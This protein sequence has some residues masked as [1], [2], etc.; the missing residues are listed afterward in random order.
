MA[1]TVE[2]LEIHDSGRVHIGNIFH[3]RTEDRCL[4]ELRSTDPRHDKA[5]LEETKG[6]LLELYRWMFDEPAFKRWKTDEASRLLWIKGDPGKGKTMLICGI[7][8]EL[9]TATKLVDPS[10]DTLLSFFYCQ[11]TDSRINSAVAVVRGLLYLLSVQ[12]LPIVAYIREKYDHAGGQLFKD[13]NAW[14]AVTEILT[15]V[16][17]DPG[18]PMTYLVIDALDECLQDLPK[19]LAYIVKTSALPR[20]KWIVS[21]RNIRDIEMKLRLGPEE[22]LDLELRDTA[23]QVSQAVR[24]YIEHCVSELPGVQDDPALREQV[25]EVMLRKA[26]GT[27]LWVSLVAK[28]LQ[29]VMPWDILDTLQEMPTDLQDIY[30]RMMENIQRMKPKYRPLCLVVLATVVGTYRPLHLEEL[31]SI[32]GL[33]D[34]ISATTKFVADIATSCGSFLTLRDDSVYII[35][36]SAED[37]LEERFEAIFMRER[38]SVQHDLFTRSLVTLSG[39][40]RRNIYKAT[41]YAQFIDIV[42]LRPSPDPLD[43]VRYACTYW[44]D[45]LGDSE[46]TTEEDSQLVYD[47]LRQ[48][49]LHWLEALGILGSILAGISSMR[50]L[51]IV[52]KVCTWP[53]HASYVDHH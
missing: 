38:R 10:A 37:F 40:L 15:T 26:S 49:F 16:L 48:H 33:P 43:P 31:A 23:E 13:A 52:L 6:G 9:R 44:V 3:N 28:E 35:H 19:L 46:Q 4:L 47:F 8:D 17:E 14:I 32:A 42:R 27:F 2:N 45:H 12:H 36:Q 22:R 50:K 7:I 18:L 11:A 53:Q 25:E 21:S 24:K 1:N 41:P 39:T 29:D 30:G 5:R 34:S 20:V 51:G